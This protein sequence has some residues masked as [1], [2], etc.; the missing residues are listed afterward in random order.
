M[1]N[2]ATFLRSASI[3]YFVV[4]TTTPKS[5]L[6]S[7]EIAADA[8]IAV[9]LVRQ[10]TI[11]QEHSP[12]SR[13]SSNSPRA[14][15]LSSTEHRRLHSPSDSSSS[16]A[17]SGSIPSPGGAILTPF[18][19]SSSS[20][21]SSADDE[22]D[23]QVASVPRNRLLRR[24]VRKTSQPRFG[25]SISENEK[26]L[27]GVRDRPLPPLPGD[28]V[29]ARGALSE[30]RTLQTDVYVG[31]PKRP[32]SPSG[33]SGHPTLEQH[34]VLPDGLY[35]GRLPLHRNM[36]PSISWGGLQVKVRD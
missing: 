15:A 14:R 28:Q 16:S 21:D 13:I 12:R 10:V 33:P 26:Y 35:K 5:I 36:L 32:R 9:S 19:P 2:P 4:Y 29:K 24:V 18:P 3:P 6:L 30:S 11:K 27:Q 31:F 22:S 17:S 25:A 34:S 23:A 20:R 8:T 7:R 1:P